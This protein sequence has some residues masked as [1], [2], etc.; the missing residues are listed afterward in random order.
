MR[1]SLIRKRPQG[2]VPR[3]PPPVAEQP[4]EQPLEQRDHPAAEQPE[5]Q[6]VEPRQGSYPLL[7]LS[8]PPLVRGVHPLR[9]G[10][11]ILDSA[12]AAAYRAGQ[13]PP[14]YVQRDVDSWLDE[15]LATSLF[16][17]VTGSSNA[18]KSRTAFAAATRMEPEPLLLVPASPRALP[19]LLAAEAA[20][21]D[22]RPA[23]LWLDDLARYLTVPGVRPALFGGRKNE[24]DW[25]NGRRAGAP[26]P[27]GAGGPP[28]RKG[29]GRPVN[30]RDPR[31]GLGGD[32]PFPDEPG[33]GGG[34]G[35]PL[36]G[37][38]VRHRDRP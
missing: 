33:G 17:L 1:W 19:D 31:L 5:Q 35:P 14:P 16:V 22:G 10:L 37:P 18:G 23:L 20:V 15:A 2:G 28:Q 38:G 29:G 25:P 8:P 12:T 27:P 7:R 13:A 4:G 26:K 30:A 9:S 24:G 36:S 32:G 11:G 6:P 21:E 3:Q 34:G